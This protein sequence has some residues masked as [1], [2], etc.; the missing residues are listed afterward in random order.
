MVMVEP[1]CE[2]LAAARRT[3]LP[4]S[5]PLEDTL[6]PYQK[7]GVKWM[8]QGLS[9]G[10][11]C[12]LADEMGVDGDLRPVHELVLIAGRSHELLELAVLLRLSVVVR[13]VV[14]NLVATS[15]V[16]GR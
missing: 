2:A 6:L 4:H 12:I 10:S 8:L 11:G 15:S 9:C 7:E 13:R 3:S 5:L 14:G 1:W 16:R